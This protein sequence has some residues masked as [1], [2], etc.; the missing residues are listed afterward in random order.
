MLYVNG[1]GTINLINKGLYV[2]TSNNFHKKRFMKQYIKNSALMHKLNYS[3]NV[4]WISKLVGTMKSEYYNCH[5][6][7]HNFETF[8]LFKFFPKQI[9]CLTNLYTLDLSHCSLTRLP[10]YISKFV[11][12]RILNLTNNKLTHLPN[13]LFDLTNLT[14]LHLEHNKLTTLSKKINQLKNLTK[15]LLNRNLI[16]VLPDLNLPELTSICICGNINL[17]ELPGSFAD[18]R[19]CCRDIDRLLN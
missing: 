12:I 11:H 5:L 9:Y 10:S 7:S 14:E 18:L 2:E 13:T 16:N 1:Y 6:R 15:L 17:Y 4:N 8:I 19:D 3:A